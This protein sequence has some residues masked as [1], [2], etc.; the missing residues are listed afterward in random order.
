GDISVTAGTVTGGGITFKAGDTADNYVQLGHG[1]RSAKSGG[2][3]NGADA[4]AGPAAGFSG[5]IDVSSAGTITFLAGTTKA[6]A[7]TEDGRLY[8]QLGHG[9]YDADNTEDGATISPNS[10]VSN[11]GHHGD[12]TV[13]SATGDIV[14]TA[15]DTALGS[16]GGGLG[17]LHYAQLGHGGYAANGN[18]YGNIT[19]EAGQGAITFTGG[20][21]SDNATDGIRN[22][23][24]LGHGGYQARG[25]FGLRDIDGSALD[26][27]A[28]T[29]L[30]DITFTSGAGT[31]ASGAS[32]SYAMLGNGGY[33]T[34]NP[35]P[36]G[37]A[38]VIL[39]PDGNTYAIDGYGPID[40]D[41]DTILDKFGP[42]AAERVG[43]AANI[44]VETIDGN[45]VFAA[46]KPATGVNSEAFVQ[47]GNGGIYSDGD[48]AGD[49]TV[50][51]DIDG[52]SGGAG[53]NITFDAT[54]NN[55]GGPHYAQLGHGGF[56]ASGGNT[57]DIAVDGSGTLTFVAGRDN[58]YVQI[59]HGGRN[60][61]RLNVIAVTGTNTFDQDTD[62]N[63]ATT[64]VSNQSPPNDRRDFANDRYYPGTHTGDITVKM[65]GDI[66]FMGFTNPDA[67]NGGGGYAQVGHG[68][69][70]NAADPTSSNGQGHNGDITLL[71]GGL[72]FDM[73]GNITAAANPNASIT[74]ESGM[75]SVSYAQVGHGGFEAFGNHFG[76]IAVAAA[77]G[78][79]FHARGGSD[80]FTDNRAG[81]YSYVQIGHGGIN[82]D[83]DPYLP[84]ALE[85]TSGTVGNT[86]SE[87]PANNAYYQNAVQALLT[88]TDANGDT[89]PDWGQGSLVPLTTFN[90]VFV[91]PATIRFV[92]HDNNP[93]TPLIPIIPTNARGQWFHIAAPGGAYDGGGNLVTG[94]SGDIAVRA[95]TGDINLA[96]A[97]SSSLRS[98]EAYVQVGHGG[99][100]T[101]GDHSGDISV[102]AQDGNVNLTAGQATTNDQGLNSYAQIGHGGSWSG[103]AM[104]G[105]IAVKALGAGHTVTGT[106]GTDNQAYVQI[107]HGGYDAS[108]LTGAGTQISTYD[109]NGVVQ[110]DTRPL[111]T[112]PAEIRGNHL[113]YWYN[114]GYLARTEYVSMFGDNA[115]TFGA[116]IE[117]RKTIVGDID[118]QATNGVVF[119]AGATGT[120]TGNISPSAY[121][122]IGHGGRSTE[123]DNTGDIN[124]NAGAGAVIFSGGN[125]NQSYAKIGHGGYEGDGNHT[126]GIT[127][128]AG[129]DG[130]NRGIDVRAGS[131]PDTFAQIGHGGTNAR[132]AARDAGNPT[133]ALTKGNSGNIVL[134]A[135]GDITFVAG[136]GNFVNSDEDSRQY[137]M[138]GHGGYDADV[139]FATTIDV[140]DTGIGHNGDITA[141]S[142][143][144]RVFFGAGDA[145]RLD[146]PSL[147][148]G[149]G[150]FHF[151]QLGH[152]GYESRGEHFGNIT[153]SAAEDITF[154]GGSSEDNDGDL[155]DYAML[156][157]GGWASR[158][159]Q[160]RD[161]ET[162]SVTAGE[163]IVF[164]AGAGQGSFVQL[165]NGGRDNR[166][167]HRGDIEVTAG[168][169]IEFSAVQ[170]RKNVSDE[171]K[172]NDLSRATNN[173]TQTSDN[174]YDLEGSNVVPGTV[175]IAIPGG[176]T[177]VDDGNGNIVVQ[178][179]I[180][181]D[182]NGDTVAENFTAG[183]IV[184]SIN[185]ISGRVIF[186]TDVNPNNVA[187]P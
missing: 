120:T 158:G 4:D 102:V 62:N 187:S 28:V 131:R 83:F 164:R 32:G 145:N 89:I 21:T 7:T 129:A 88:T 47:L 27:I 177:L 53:G 169:N 175:V 119:T 46:S 168:G 111:S 85:S 93:L 103:G 14:F 45:I 34:D 94:S 24:Q 137:V 113:Q 180:A 140:F 25:D 116:G 72:T 11:I 35:N 114:P 84:R 64:G 92:D 123:S 176:P 147:G 73:D 148:I 9:G 95:M 31:P 91:D 182:A 170:D 19:V 179:D 82:A 41:G 142:S 99:L 44:V 130:S 109:Q 50:K 135:I 48:H 68:G 76:D 79:D 59:G 186:T 141:I 54:G 112:S 29:A 63:Y 51:A 10:G 39:M 78:V 128:T 20:A 157:H 70:R 171:E 57:G 105:D 1:G 155:V 52:S 60:D 167:D 173:G 115:A 43:H 185:Y 61:H 174:I 118:V 69:Y 5:N 153:V 139:H 117:F 149:E 13:T 74:F 98:R 37:D 101:G 17:R 156:G 80:T 40:S 75:Q 81:Q 160:G 138:L 178:A 86:F 144:G 12:I 163:D 96:G 6:D 121:A 2:N 165:G 8:A 56:F 38:G 30:K 55:V 33:D 100:Y 151:A 77:A 126:G 18:H 134:N 71:A 67:N 184:A 15:G 127:V 58:S 154:L 36:G 22:Y 181:V 107:G 26:T 125:S 124:V 3:T 132:S 159:N 143:G 108:Y 110:A 183:Q 150:R 166:G 23:A 97:T 49:I 152:G 65:L 16:N 172:N 133:V 106:A 122:Q 87:N 146:N 90:Q 161:G 104:S 42:T 162:I 136:T 66:S